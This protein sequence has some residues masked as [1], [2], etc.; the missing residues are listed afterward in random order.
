[1][2]SPRRYANQ[3]EHVYVDNR[4][5]RGNQVGERS[6]LAGAVLKGIPESESH[7]KVFA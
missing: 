6:L 1:M 4:R 7:E 3:I 2:A 5:Y